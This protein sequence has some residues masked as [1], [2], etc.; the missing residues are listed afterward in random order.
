MRA[1]FTRVGGT[2]A[3]VVLAVGVLAGP[4]HA[5]PSTIS[6][7]ITAADT[8]L[9]VA[10]CATVYDLDYNWAGGGCADDSGQWAAE[11]ET[12][13][14]YKVEVSAQDPIYR[15]Q[16]S[17]GAQTFDEAAVVTAPTVVD[18]A[19]EY[20]REVGD[21]TL[22]GTITEDGTGDPLQGCATVYTEALDY[23]ASAC[24][25]EGGHWSADRLV[26]GAGYK[27]E[28]EAWDGVHLGEWADD[29]VDS[30]HA[31]VITA[32]ATVDVGLARGG[33]LE[34]TLTRADGQPAA[35]VSVDATTTDADGGARTEAFT[36]TDD[37][38]Q[39]SV[40]VHPGEYS[41]HFTDYPT[42]QWAVGQTSAETATL[43]SVTADQTVRVDDRF[44]AA[45]TVEGTVRSDAGHAPVAGACVTILT[46][47][48]DPDQASWVGDACTD[49]SG[50][51][52]IQVSEPGTYIAE[53][54]DPEGRFVGEY[55]GNTRAIKRATVFTVQRG[56]PAT[57]NA[58]LATGAVL[59][60]RAIDSKTGA[61]I[62]EVCPNAFVGSKGAYARGQVPTC[63]D[64]DGRWTVRGLPAGDF[65]LAFSSYSEHRVYSTTWAFGKDS[66]KEANLITVR[67]GATKSVRDV[68]M[69]PG[70]TVS[71]VVTGPD[72]A[73]VADAWV[74]VGGGFPGR[75]GPGEGQWSART[76]A[77]GHY[78]I[79]GVPKG[80][81]TAFVYLD[82]YWGPLAPEWYRDARTAKLAT[83]FTVRPLRT[84]A[85]NAQLNPA[86]TISGSVVN[87][88]GSP[89]DRYLMGQVFAA[90]GSHVGDFD[91]FDGNTF[92][93][94][95][96]PQGTFTISLTDPETGQT[97]WYDGATS[98]RDAT[99]VRVGEGGHVEVTVHLP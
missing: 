76:D 72:G 97:Y 17:G 58:S 44:L 99:R 42:E 6:G 14:S 65:A 69:V 67:A 88:D 94:S 66:Q 96:L 9:P 10:G 2:I 57:V 20:S 91:V 23:V 92:T 60:G 34:G 77:N 89:V 32:P 13:V 27:V 68:K 50:K 83:T 87:S 31:D 73:P 56:A 25:D 45:A 38:G 7:T 21:A 35:Y 41:V 86:A 93:T 54:T 64:A 59:T 19:L 37:Q 80:T 71:G 47:A 48:A 4:A 78:E 39:W 53:F 5:E 84:T 26:E 40:L 63:T 75:A 82:D 11:V 95:A 81:Y 29:A 85:V 46:P 36:Q 12:G 55:S 98:R 30:E 33:H 70:G 43:F 90:D 8:G 28:V 24:S 62:A 49:A 22:S 61:P 18:T 15:T 16:W 1:A 52:T 51:Y 74:N 79:T 3:T